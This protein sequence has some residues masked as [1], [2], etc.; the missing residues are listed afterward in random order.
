MNPAYEEDYDSENPPATVEEASYRLKQSIIWEFIDSGM[1][2]EM[3]CSTFNTW[4]EA[5][6]KRY[7]KA[8]DN[9]KRFFTEPTPLKKVKKSNETKDESINKHVKTLREYLRG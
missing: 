4:N 1:Y 3:P 2:Q 8:A 9:L 7:I 5:A 6:K